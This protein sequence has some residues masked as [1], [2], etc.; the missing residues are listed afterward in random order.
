MLDIGSCC[1]ALRQLVRFCD[2]SVQHANSALALQRVHKA[3]ASKAG[4]WCHHGAASS[5][6]LAAK[7]TTHQRYKKNLQPNYFTSVQKWMDETCF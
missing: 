5:I 7:T 1:A 2:L 4:H 6:E 3:Y